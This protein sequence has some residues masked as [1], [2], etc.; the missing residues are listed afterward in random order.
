MLEAI[1]HTEARLVYHAGLLFAV[2][3]F[4][5]AA[6][7]K[8]RLDAVA[9]P[10]LAAF[11]VILRVLGHSPSLARMTAVIWLFNSTAIF[12]YMASG[13]L[14]RLLPMVFS[15]WTGMN[16]AA[17]VGLARV[18][19]AQEMQ[20]ARRPDQW[21]PPGPLGALCGLAVLVL[22][23]GSFFIAIAMGI[24]TG[25]AVAG[26]TARLAALAPRAAAYTTILVPVLLLSAFCESISIRTGSPGA[27]ETG[28][29]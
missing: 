28:G 20:M 25:A 1:F 7:V 19:R 5:G 2:G 22:E 23:L 17:V 6:V 8:L 16:I 21:R 3:I 24:S 13:S 15:I 29:M 18:G 12:L 9:R 14:H 4:A 11:R 27:D 26:G 10:A